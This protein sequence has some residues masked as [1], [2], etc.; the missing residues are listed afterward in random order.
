M[1]KC[2]LVDELNV[3]LALADFAFESE[4]GLAGED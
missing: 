2:V 3:A 1:S 4:F